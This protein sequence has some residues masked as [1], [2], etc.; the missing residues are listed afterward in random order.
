MKSPQ[1]SEVRR[2]LLPLGEWDRPPVL[3]EIA[4]QLARLADLL[5]EHFQEKRA[6]EEQARNV[7]AQFRGPWTIE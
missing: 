4:A 5:D 1:E 6:A 2:A 7:R 3:R